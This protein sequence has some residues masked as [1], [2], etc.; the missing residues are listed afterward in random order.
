M[1][2]GKTFE[3]NVIKEA[4]KENCRRQK[5]RKCLIIVIRDDGG[6]GGKEEEGWRWE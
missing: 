4:E 5:R 6:G 3:E 2:I 1:K